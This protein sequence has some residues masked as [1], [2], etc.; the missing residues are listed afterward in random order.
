MFIEIIKKENLNCSLLDFENYYN[1]FQI[2]IN[3][4]EK[5]QF[6]ELY[7][8][9]QIENPANWKYY[10]IIGL[11]GIVYLQNIKPYV[12]WLIPLNDDNID[13]IMNNHKQNIISDIKLL[14]TIEYFKNN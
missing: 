11:N 4:F 14:K 12:W 3:I 8:N 2:E 5:K 1:N 6:T 10:Y 7:N 13:I 9:I